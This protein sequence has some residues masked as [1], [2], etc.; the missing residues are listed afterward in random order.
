[1]STE[2]VPSSVDIDNVTD[3]LTTLA[4]DAADTP[5][6]ESEVLTASAPTEQYPS[7]GSV[8]DSFQVENK[9]YSEYSI[10]ETFVIIELVMTSLELII[11]IFAASKMPRWR[12]NYRNQML[13]QLT[14]ARFIK[15]IIFTLKFLDCQGN[16]ALDDIVKN[17]LYCFQIY[18][19]FVIVV[20]VFFFIKHM[21][22][23][24]I[25]VLV[26]ISHNSFY[27][28]LFCSWL[29]PIPISVVCTTVI[30]TGLMEKW[31]VTLMICSIFRWPL[32]FIGTS[33]YIAIVYR[34]MSDNKRQFA[35]SLA[36]VTFL[37]CL[38]INVYLFSKDVMDL[39]CITSLMTLLISYVSGFLMN[40]LILVLYIILIIFS[41]NN[42]TQSSRTLPDYSLADVNMKC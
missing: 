26:K 3:L 9:L 37:L 8:L 2:I 7:N 25:I 4:P 17:V 27:R 20:L 40:F 32:I 28:V 14:F 39:W 5:Y 10:F 13:M 16:I 35:R 38:N 41:Y 12:R 42:K 11:S 22:N 1:M 6:N 29:I 23:S 33:L 19:D 30:V 15:R 34:V 21:Y 31:Y 36:V 18:M 24:L